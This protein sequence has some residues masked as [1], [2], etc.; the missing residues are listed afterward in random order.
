MF[1]RSNVALPRRIISLSLV[2]IVLAGASVVA[3]ARAQSRLIVDAPGTWK[4]WKFVAVPSARQERG[5]TAADVKSFEAQLLALNAILRRAPGVATP[6]GYSVETWGFVA[7]FA[8][9]AIDPPKAASLPIGGG[10]DFGAFPIFEYDRNGKTIR[11]DTGETDLLVFHVNMPDAAVVGGKR[12][13]DWV[14]VDAETF[15]EPAAR[16]EVGGFPRYGDVIVIKKNPKPIWTPVTMESAVGLIVASR[17]H[18][19]EDTRQVVERYKASLADHQNPAKRA[20]RFAGFKTVAAMQPDPKKFIAEME[21]VEKEV[22]AGMLRDLS[23]ESGAMKDFLDTERALADGRAWLKDLPAAE[24]TAATCY[25]ASGTTPRSRF[26]ADT[27][28]GC[29]KVVRPNWAFFD[30]SLPR[31][32][33]QLLIVPEVA[34]CFENQPANPSTPAGCPANRQLLQTWDRQAVL[35][36]LK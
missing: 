2:L 27:G 31:S 14:L 7:G 29:V 32:T 26:H 5:V 34:R 6:R 21:A 9:Q 33:P 23:P 20:E 11:A 4:P 15:L 35:D 1:T 16:G 28:A 30:A 24:R 17:A 13:P 36:W 18:D 8:P 10:V 19:L 25:V 3:G 12:I 22:E